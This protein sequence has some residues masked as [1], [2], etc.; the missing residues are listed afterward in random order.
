MA[1]S[2]TIRVVLEE[3]ECM[4]GEISAPETL[5]DTNHSV[6]W[7]E[8]DGWVSELVSLKTTTLHHYDQHTPE[9]VSIKRRKGLFMMRF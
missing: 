9:D 5:L 8:I 7:N 4:M 6:W 1:T 2:D 3:K